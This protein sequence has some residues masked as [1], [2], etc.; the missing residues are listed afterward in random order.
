[1]T[2]TVLKEFSGKK[3]L[4]LQGPMGFF[5]WG[6]GKDLRAAGAEVFKI[7]FCGGDLFYYP[8]GATNYRGD[9]AAWPEFL[10][11]F[12][13]RN[14]IDAIFLYGDCRPIHKV[15]AACSGVDLYVFEEGYVRPDYITF[16]KHGVNGHSRIP[17]GPDFYHRNVAPERVPTRHVGDTWPPLARAAIWYHFI[18]AILWPLFPRYKHHRS[19]SIFVGLYWLR[20]FYRKA[21]YAFLERN[22]I[23]LLLGYSS[24]QYFLVPLQLFNDSQISVHSRFKSVEQFLRV[25]V[26]SFS[27]YAPA[28]TLLVVKHHPVD[29]GYSD[30]TELLRNLAKKFRI[31]GR[32]LYVHDLHLPMLLQHARGVVVINSTVGLSSL[33]HGTPTKTCGTAIYDIEGLTYRGSLADFWRDAGDFTVDNDLY[34]RFLSHVVRTT[35]LNGSFYRKLEGVESAAGVIYRDSGPAEASGLPF[36]FV[37]ANDTQARPPLEKPGRGRKGRVHD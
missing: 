9:L 24:R 22:V 31:E 7:N 17:K 12:V 8:K 28:G 19:L 23:K 25:C 37:P 16:E 29:R 27:R 21:K 15:A 1:M 30:Y 10:K 4:L 5:F 35:Q 36:A 26:R 20:S 18:S 14:G 34:L 6:L 32:L 2:G 13:A 11:N 3:V 33:H